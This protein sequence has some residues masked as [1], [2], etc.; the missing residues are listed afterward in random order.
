[1]IEREDMIAWLNNPITKGLCEI[2]K[3]DRIAAEDDAFE[4]FL[5]CTKNNIMNRTYQEIFGLARL[6]T[7]NF[8]LSK[9][10]SPLYENLAELAEAQEDAEKPKE[11]SIAEFAKKIEEVLKHAKK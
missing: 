5:H 8:I 3:N 6:E 4:T 11:D 10:F 7:V 1:M 9:T 2:L